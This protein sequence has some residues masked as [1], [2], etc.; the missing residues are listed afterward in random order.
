MPE[1]PHNPS[2][3][4]KPH[5]FRLLR[6]LMIFFDGISGSPYGD[7]VQIGS[8]ASG[9]MSAAMAKASGFTWPRHDGFRATTAT[10]ANESGRKDS[11]SR[12]GG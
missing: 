11:R 1:H 8:V 12:Q 2:A 4:R 3:V 9:T 7:H 10:I 6:G 5:S